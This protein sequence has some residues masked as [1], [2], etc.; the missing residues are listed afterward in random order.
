MV[1]ST[2]SH[3]GVISMPRAANAARR[4]VSFGKRQINAEMAT[5]GPGLLLA[6][7]ERR[8]VNFDRHLQGL[9]V[10]GFV[11]RQAGRDL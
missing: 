11:E 1:I 5:F 2:F 6:C 8:Q 4:A 7:A 10:A 3:P 9:A